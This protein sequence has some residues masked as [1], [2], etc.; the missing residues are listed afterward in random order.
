M[1]RTLLGGGVMPSL[2]YAVAVAYTAD[3]TQRL[4]SLAT[5][6]DDNASPVKA[7][8]MNLTKILSHMD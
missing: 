1:G 3:T 8:N 4:Q 2:I 6:S 7:S 5:G